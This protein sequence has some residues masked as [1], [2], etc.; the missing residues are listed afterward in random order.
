MSYLLGSFRDECETVGTRYTDQSIWASG[1]KCGGPDRHDP[2]AWDEA[3]FFEIDIFR[4]LLGQKDV[5][6][7]GDVNES[8]TSACRIHGCD[9]SVIDTEFTY[10]HTIFETVNSLSD[11][12]INGSL[13][14]FYPKSVF[15]VLTELVLYREGEERVEY[16]DV[17]GAATAL[18]C[19]H[20][21]AVVLRLPA[22]DITS[23]TSTVFRGSVTAQVHIDFEVLSG[24]IFFDYFCV[25]VWCFSILVSRI[26]V[27]PVNMAPAFPVGAGFTAREGMR[28]CVDRRNRSVAGETTQVVASANHDGWF[29]GVHPFLHGP[30]FVCFPIECFIHALF[31]PSISVDRGF[32][33][34][35]IMRVAVGMRVVWRAGW[36]ALG[37]PREPA[38]PSLTAPLDYLDEKRVVSSSSGLASRMG[39]VSSAFGLSVKMT[40]PLIMMCS[41]LITTP[42]RDT[43]GVLDLSGMCRVSGAPAVAGFGPYPHNVRVLDQADMALL[44]A[45]T[46]RKM[47]SIISPFGIV[48]RGT[49]GIARTRRE[50][51]CVFVSLC[52]TSA[53]CTHNVRAC[54]PSRVLI[55]KGRH[56]W[57]RWCG[58]SRCSIRVRAGMG[59][60]GAGT[61]GSHRPAQPNCGPRTVRRR[62]V[63]V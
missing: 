46:N 14:G 19:R 62:E 55:K 36:L 48:G 11:E 26:T 50:T 37:T 34:T 22:L 29:A 30:F 10:L 39:C 52:L 1:G 6:F 24:F 8:K 47:I 45:L 35:L 42:G 33:F 32:F 3:S 51:V 9:T 17:L 5:V 43:P 21:K 12:S 25:L 56:H 41:A 13:I 31:F 60:V 27:T 15:A 4:K 54:F 38:D 28:F 49:S 18:S 40:E 57:Q 58:S 20:G 23:T 44:T 53:L 59:R 61:L 7:I 63:A 16:G 2:C